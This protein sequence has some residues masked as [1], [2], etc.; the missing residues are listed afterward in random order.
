MKVIK[1]L[2]RR[3]TPGRGGIAEDVGTAA[4]EMSG[5]LAPIG[6]A[7]LKVIL[8][9]GHHKV[10]STSLQDYLSRNAAAL[11]RAGI[12]YPYVDFE[13]MAYM[14]ATAAGH[15]Q[16][17]GSLPINVREPHNALAF[18]ML[19]TQK[20][21]TVPAY[22]KRLPALPQMLH[23]IRQQIR[24]SQPHTVILAAE[25]FANF[26]AVSPELI[27]QLVEHFPGAEFTVVATLR[28]IDAYLASWHGQRLKFGHKL[29]PLREDGVDSYG[30]GIHFNYR[31][32]IEG[33]LKALPEARVILRNYADV[34]ANGGSVNDF[35]T[36]TGLELP[37]G[38][39]P[40]RRENDSI[41]RGIYEIIRRANVELP[42]PQAAELRH[43]LRTLAPKLN[44]PPSHSVELFGAENRA[45]MLER[46]RPIDTWL[47][48]VMGQEGFFDDLEAVLEP[49]PLPELEAA[50][51][52]LEQIEARKAWRESWRE[53]EAVET[54]LSGLA[55]G[56]TTPDKTA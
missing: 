56:G 17:E 42:Q 23:A 28:R 30:M 41:H 53:D 12:L 26:N 31:L 52:A 34:R 33:W 40:E 9:I 36:Q 5:R 45:R 1:R 43:S 16:P 29:K 50:R 20:N 46:F 38:L 19:A 32:M 24:F 47:G 10:G 2:L 49:D 7:P 35:I 44:L 25:V 14:A 37:K 22:H 27:D 54:F 51:I 6:Q 3:P 18:R 21:G 13:G 8:F 4:A 48:E 55:G 15:A 11:S 39:A